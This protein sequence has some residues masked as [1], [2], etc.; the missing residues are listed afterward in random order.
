M[1]SFELL[2]KTLE[3][4]SF[5]RSFF[6]LSLKSLGVF[7]DNYF[8]LSPGLVRNKEIQLVLRRLLKKIQE[9]SEFKDR[10]K[11]TLE[12][13]EWNSFFNLFLIVCE[14]GTQEKLEAYHCLKV[15][16]T[17]HQ[18][19]LDVFCEDLVKSRVFRDTVDFDENVRN[20]ALGLILIACDHEKCKEAFVRSRLVF[21]LYSRVLKKDSGAEKVVR[22]IVRKL[23]L[24][25]DIWLK[26]EVDEERR[27]VIELATS[28]DDDD[29]KRLAELIK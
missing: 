6:F 24:D 14:F 21:N 7:L 11:G 9:N 1:Q 25:R 5:D 16:V 15:V 18:D 29:L 2:E 22:E 8:E 20:Q 23:S 13:F 26:P 27:R 10:V 4:S 28:L 19:L 3:R 17:R 12:N